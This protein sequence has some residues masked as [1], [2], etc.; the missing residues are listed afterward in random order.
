MSG[1]RVRLTG[2]AR[3]HLD[4]VDKWWRKNRPTTTDRVTEEFARAASLLAHSPGIGKRYA[5]VEEHDIK[6]RM[7]RTTPYYL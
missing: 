1:Y 2:R 6:R 3:R 4:V 7:L 5:V